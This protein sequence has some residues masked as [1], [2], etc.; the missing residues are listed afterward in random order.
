MRLLT[1]TVAVLLMAAST[2]LAKPP[3]RDVAE[4]DD[5]VMAVAIADA[6]RKSCDDI[7]ARLLRAYTTLNGLKSDARARGY[8]DEEVEAYVTSKSE[9]ARM[10]AKAERFLQANGVR[11]DDIPALCRFGKAQ[12]RS[13][14]E[15]GELLR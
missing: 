2:G 10:K 14:T 8:T 11:P 12:I 6:I 3:L 1:T 4:I 13:R 15:I 5:A 7:N 9:K